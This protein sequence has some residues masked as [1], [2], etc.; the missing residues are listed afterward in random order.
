MQAPQCPPPPTGLHMVPEGPALVPRKG[1]VLT[2]VLGHMAVSSSGTAA[3]KT[4]KTDKMRHSIDAG[5]AGGVATLSI[6]VGSWR[7]SVSPCKGSCRFLVHVC[8]TCG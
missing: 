3:E 4:E 8:Y 7:L 6:H 5:V 1:G 2:S